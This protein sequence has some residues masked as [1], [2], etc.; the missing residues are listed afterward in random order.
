ML[1]NI[2]VVAPAN[3]P[4]IC[5]IPREYDHKISYIKKHTKLS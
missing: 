5:Y 4:H 1:N 2:K 3:N